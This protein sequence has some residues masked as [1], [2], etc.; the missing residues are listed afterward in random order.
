MKLHFLKP[1]AEKK[2]LLLAA[3]TPIVLIALLLLFES[4]VEGSGIQTPF[5]AVWYM[6]VTLSTVGYGDLTPVSIGGKVIGLIFVFSSIGL[7]GYWIGNVTSNINEYMEKK[8]LGFL[9]TNMENHTIVIGWDDFGNMVTDQVVKSGNEVAVITDNKEHIDIIKSTFEGKNVFALY[10]DFNLFENLKKV[11]ID[12][13]SSVFLNFHD[14]TDALVYFINIRKQYCNLKYVVSLNNSALKQTFIAAGVTFAV[15]KNE[16][17]SKLVASYIFEPDVAYITEDLMSTAINEFDYDILEYKV[18][19][20][21]PFIGRSYLDV[22]IDLKK[23]FNSVIIGI[24]RFK[25][26]SYQLLYNPKRSLKINENDFMVI[27]A[28]GLGK[29]KIEKI[30]KVQEG[31]F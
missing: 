3:F 6:F 31:R 24:S 18:I 14:D 17:A 22:F 7:L 16:I 23:D 25:E 10:T 19:E 4:G 27:I 26:G 30:F 8:K 11:N 1:I 28:N 21:N 13:A 5:D 9:G 2:Y 29:S 12:K 20:G 15:S